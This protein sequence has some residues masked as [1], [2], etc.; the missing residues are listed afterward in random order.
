MKYKLICI[1]AD[2]KVTTKEYDTPSVPL[3]D[4][5]RCVGG[6][7]EVVSVPFLEPLEPFLLMCLDEDGKFK[8]KPINDLASMLYN[9]PFDVI[10]GDV[11]LGT[12]FNE[13]PSAEPDIYALPEEMSEKVEGF[14][15]RMIGD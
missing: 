15:K 1:S 10:V 5:Q 12:R 4:L 14:L 13:D 11:V 3:E 9:N 2:C 8:E 7:I 6:Y